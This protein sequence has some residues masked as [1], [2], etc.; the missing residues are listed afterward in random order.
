MVSKSKSGMLFGG[1]A[2]LLIAVGLVVLTLASA[3]FAYQN[4]GSAYYFLGHQALYG[5]LPGFFLFLFFWKINYLKLQKFY[6]I[7]FIL[8]LALLGLTLIPGIGTEINS[9]RSW[10]ALGG[11]SFQPSEFAKLGLIIFLAGFLAKNEEA[12]SQKFTSGFL[13]FFLFV[14]A[15]CGLV[16]LQPDMGTAML[17]GIIGAT[18]YFLANGKILYLGVLG[19]LGGIGTA[20]LI[21]IAP[22]R[23]ARLTSFLNPDFDPQGIGYH[24]NQALIAIGSGGFWGLGLGNSRQKFQYVPEVIGDSI[25]A[26]MGEE[27]GFLLALAFIICFF[28]F[29]WQ[30]FKIASATENKFGY[31]IVS[32]IVIWFGWQMFLNIGSM[33]GIMP[34][35]GLTLPFISY[36]GTSLA[37]SMA[38]V[39]LVLNIARRS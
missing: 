34:L 33:I 11:F 19:I 25:F 22:Y 28:V 30:G 37:A 13:R 5:L 31:Y 17:L 23:T 39:G 15:V 18:M 35:T 20:I 6:K 2:F 10:L 36:G 16:V 26:I 3:P 7:I 38:A 32:G 4:F 29:L 14:F 21:K 27:L 1:Q 9:A 8:C 24:I 12:V